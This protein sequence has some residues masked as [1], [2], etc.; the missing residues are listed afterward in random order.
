MQLLVR[1]Q[2]HNFG[3]FYNS[4]STSS[5]SRILGNWAVFSAVAAF[6]LSR[7]IAVNSVALLK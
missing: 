1:E 6:R 4:S 3:F 2:G 7:V 5:I